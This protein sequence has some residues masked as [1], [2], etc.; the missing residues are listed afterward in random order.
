[1]IPEMTDKV[2]QRYAGKEADLYIALLIFLVGLG[3]F[4]LGKLSLLW[5][6][7]EP[8]SIT[9]VDSAKEN[10]ENLY[11][12]STAKIHPSEEK[13]TGRIVASRSGNIYHF[14]WCPGALRIKEENKV[15]FN[16]REDA[17]KNGYK[18]ASNCPGL[19]FLKSQ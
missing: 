19:S 1:M 7:K 4:G 18:P 11:G 6:H 8:L 13:T 3:G 17:E 15:W 14:P 10:M 16:S 2:K 5:P 12:S 9:D